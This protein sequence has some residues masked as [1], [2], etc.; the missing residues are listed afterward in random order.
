MPSRIHHYDLNRR[1]FLKTAAGAG[2]AMVLPGCLPVG[3]G[4]NGL[5]A[6][7]A[8]LRANY[9]DSL[10]DVIAAGFDLVPPP[11]VVGKRVLL[12]PNLVDLPREGKPVVTNPAVIVA[13]AEAFRRR[14]A[15]EVI[16]A[17][18]PA[19]QRDAW[20]IVDAI[21]LAGLLAEHGLQFIDLNLADVQ[22]VPNVGGNTG[23]SSLYCTRPVLEADVIVSMPKM[24][25]HHW[26]GVTLSMKNMFGTLPGQV[27]GWPRN[28]FHLPNFNNAVLDF[29]LTTPPDYAI[30][31]GI[32]GL[33]GDG[34]IR[35]TPID[36][37]VIVMGNNPPAVDATAARVMGVRPEAVEY[38]RRAAGWLGPIDE[39]S[40]EQRGESIA[41]V[42]RPFQLLAHQA[43]LAL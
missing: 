36:V 28:V 12:K 5:T 34:P 21:G 17:D 27:Y 37:G 35:G 10:A 38:L 40:I 26:A 32:V 20:Q 2:A 16:V 24:K 22:E 23:R 43:L 33:E 25:V 30:I 14:G 3:L 31:D 19:L 39:S 42:H 6:A 8:I 15:A 29:N 41:S 7:T 4:D 18:G 9:G 11:D 13:A 1:D